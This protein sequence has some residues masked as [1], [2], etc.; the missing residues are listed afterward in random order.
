M[1]LKTEFPPPPCF[2]FTDRTSLCPVAGL[3]PLSKQLVIYF[4]ETKYLEWLD[5]DLRNSLLVL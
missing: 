3:L 4:T 5:A 2:S 1:H